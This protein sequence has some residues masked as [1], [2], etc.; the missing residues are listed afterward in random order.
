MLARAIAVLLF[1][2]P[3]TAHGHGGGLDGLGCHH[4]R[5]YRGARH[6]AASASAAVQNQRSPRAVLILVAA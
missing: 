2:T 5:F 6:P 3:I 1:L 4:F